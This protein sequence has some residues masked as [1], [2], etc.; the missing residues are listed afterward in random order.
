MNATQ[1]G[2]EIKHDYLLD[3]I[4]MYIVFLLSA[5]TRVTQNFQ[6]GQPRKTRDSQQSSF[7]EIFA[8]VLFIL[9]AYPFRATHL[10]SYYFNLVLSPYPMLMQRGSLK[11]Y[12]IY[13][14]FSAETSA[15]RVN[16]V[17][18]MIYIHNLLKRY[19]IQQLQLITT[20]IK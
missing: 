7:Y 1:F 6:Q 5:V 20:I 3:I 4:C 15:A 10:F 11:S 12:V 16:L 8:Q 18:S 14:R 17:L 9:V 2:F 19:D 13:F